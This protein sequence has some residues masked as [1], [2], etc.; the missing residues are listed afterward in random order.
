MPGASLDHRDFLSIFG[1]EVSPGDLAFRIYLAWH[2]GTQRLYMAIERIDDVYINSYEGG[3]LSSMGLY[4]NV[5]FMVDGDH[6]GGDFNAR[7]FGLATNEEIDL[8]KGSQ[9]Q[10]CRAISV[11]PDDRTL[12]CMGAARDWVSLPPYADAGGF[13]DGESPNTSG[14]ELYV[15]AWDRLDW[16]GAEHSVPSA[17]VAGKIIGFQ[18]GVADFDT[19][20]GDFKGFHTI[21]GADEVGFTAD[22]FVDGELIPCDVEDCGEVPGMSAVRRDSWGRIKASF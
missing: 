9:A 18:L 11:S 13:Q 16:R 3:H 8:F 14:V 1:E 12:N 4:D 22:D 20:P 19:E 5:E 15:T 2:S 21:Y 6:S 17:L 10:L 7:F